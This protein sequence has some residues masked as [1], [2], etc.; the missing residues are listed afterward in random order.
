[1]RVFRS[2]RFL[3]LALCAVFLE[4]VSFAGT[5]TAVEARRIEARFL[6]PCCW[7]ESLATHDSPV[8]K[9]LRSEIERLVASGQTES[10]IVDEYVARYGERILSEP[11]GAQFQVLTI[12]PIAVFGIAFLFVIRFLSLSWRKNY[13]DASYVALPAAMESEIEW[14]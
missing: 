3:L 2:Y 9:Q 13:S 5:E 14:L 4:S 10:Q 7:H 12:T 1:M 11:R 8:A 6:A